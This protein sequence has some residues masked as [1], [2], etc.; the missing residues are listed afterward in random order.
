MRIVSRKPI[1]RARTAALVLAV[2]MALAFAGGCGSSTKTISQTG[3]NGQVTT[4]TVPNIHFAKTKFVLHVG[5]AF[6]AFHRYIYKPLK[7]GAFGSGSK[8]RLKALLKAAAAA[9]FAV[10]ELKLAHADALSDNRLR[11]LA[12]KVDALF[13]RLGSLGTALKGGVLNPAD[14]IGAS[15][16]VTAL[17]SGSG[18]LGVGIAD[19]ASAV[20]G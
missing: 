8:G 1:R 6:G 20:H 3:A 11:P 18:A 9:L 13:S 19:I 16:A 5:L 10:H 12:E 4:S 14:I 17:G 15:G 7:A 2:A